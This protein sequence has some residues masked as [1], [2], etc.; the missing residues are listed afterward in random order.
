[1]GILIMGLSTR[2]YCKMY[3][4]CVLYNLPDWR[5]RQNSRLKYNNHFYHRVMSAFTRPKP[6]TNN[7]CRSPSRSFDSYLFFFFCETPRIQPRSLLGSKR[8]RARKTAKNKNFTSSR[9]NQME[10]A[11]TPL[12]YQDINQIYVEEYEIKYNRIYLLNYRV[13]RKYTAD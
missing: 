5:D 1:M 11:I 6:R 9:N 13:L 8:T 7:S 12:S 4:S 10:K 3:I 2:H